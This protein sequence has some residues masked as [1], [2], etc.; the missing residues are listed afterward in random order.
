MNIK[1]ASFLTLTLIILGLIWVLLI[2]IT[3]KIFKANPYPVYYPLFET[4]QF[5]VCVLPVIIFAKKRYEVNLK[6]QL[7]AFNPVI[8]FLLL[9]VT[10]LLFANILPFSQPIEF[11]KS[12]SKGKLLF[13][14]YRNSSF[15]GWML[16]KF[17]NVVIFIPVFEEFL[18][19]GIILK[20]LLTKYTPIF[21][22][23]VSSLLFA[24]YHLNPI[25]IIYLTMYGFLLGWVYCFSKSL[26]IPVF[27]H[28]LINLLAFFTKD[29]NYDLNSKTLLVYVL[30]VSL[31]ALLICLIIKHL[32]LKF[33]E[34][35][36]KS[37]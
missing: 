23:I 12:F 22:I 31:S 5:F 28:I 21:S 9:I 33:I 37:E 11:V 19:R 17:L 15:D 3:F 6:S 29:V 7:K 25:G 13:F 34:K 32:Q 16:V 18:F 26:Y 8:F 35:I 30:F 24:I 2:A 10:F 27:L 14:Q 4:G 36:E 1:Q 20:M